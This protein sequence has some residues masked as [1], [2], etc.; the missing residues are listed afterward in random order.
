MAQMRELEGLPVAAVSCQEV[1]E[2]VGGEVL[3]EASTSWQEITE[4]GE[5]GD[6]RELT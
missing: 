5:T 4:W 1:A 6:C 2:I 3:P